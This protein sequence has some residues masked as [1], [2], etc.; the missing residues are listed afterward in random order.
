MFKLKRNE[1]L[2]ISN[3]NE[4]HVSNKSQRITNAMGIDVT[5]N[6]SL[7]NFEDALLR[8]KN[9]REI[10]VVY[11]HKI[12]K[13][14]SEY[15]ISPNYLEET[16]KLCKKHEIQSVSLNQVSKFWNH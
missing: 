10:L 4:I 16:F 11:A 6:I 7:A 14:P 3:Y 2:L 12:S 13:N 5:Y 1:L 9:N 8:A 15:E